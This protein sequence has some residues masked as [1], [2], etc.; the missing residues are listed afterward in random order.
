MLE[1]TNPYA[2]LLLGLFPIYFLLKKTK[3]KKIRFKFSVLHWETKNGQQKKNFLIRSS[4]FLFLLALSFIII[5]IS[6][7]K[8]KIQK[9][10]FLD[11][12]ASVMFAL[13][14]SPSMSIADME[15][16]GKNISRLDF[17]KLCIKKFML[18]NKNIAVGLCAFASESSLIVPETLNQNIFFERLDALD[19]SELGDGTALG[20][21]LASAALHSGNGNNSYIILLCDGENNSGAVNPLSVTKIIA[22]RGYKFFLIGIGTN[23]PS[24]INYTASDDLK[25]YKG[26][27]QQ[28]FDEEK[29]RMLTQSAHGVYRFAD[30]TTALYDTVKIISEQLEKSLIKKTEYEIFYIQK[31]FIAAALICVSAAWAIKKI[32]LKAVI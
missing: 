19:V 6:D 12:D 18:Q 21:G 2:L 7:P 1:F 14:I 24:E 11:N 29:L 30:S 9:H 22:E 20:N 28:H 26:I 8:V 3:L 15:H 10:I 27:R 31:Y 5:A 23:N 16:N 17:A 4:R 13:D 25:V 32:I